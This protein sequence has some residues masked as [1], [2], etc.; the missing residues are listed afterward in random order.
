MTQVHYIAHHAPRTGY[1]VGSFSLRGPRGPA[2]LRGPF[3]EIASAISRCP[4]STTYTFDAIA[5]N[6][7]SARRQGLTTSSLDQV[8]DIPWVEREGPPLDHAVHPDT[9]ARLAQLM[10]LIEAIGT[11]AEKLSARPPYQVA[12]SPNTMRF[13]VAFS[14]DYHRVDAYADVDARAPFVRWVI[15]ARRIDGQSGSTLHISWPWLSRTMQIDFGAIEIRRIV[16]PTAI[17]LTALEQQ[18]IENADAVEGGIWHGIPHVWGGD[19][20]GQPIVRGRAGGCPWDLRD[21]MGRDNPNAPGVDPTFG[22]TWTALLWPVEGLPDPRRLGDLIVWGVDC[23]FARRPQH[24]DVLAVMEPDGKHTLH[25]GQPY[26]AEDAAFFGVGPQFRTGP[27][28]FTTHDHEHRSVAPLAV[29]AALTGDVAAR[30]VAES[31]LAAESW[32]RSVVMGW[33]QPGRGNGLPWIAGSLLARVTGDT[34]LVVAWNHHS[35]ERLRQLRDKRLQGYP[36]TVAGTYFR[37]SPWLVDG[38]EQ[39]YSDPYE[40]ATIVVACWLEFRRTGDREF[41][42]I[43]LELGRGVVAGH[44]RDSDGTARAAYNMRWLGGNWPHTPGGP[45]NGDLRPGGDALSRWAG[46]GLHC[47]LLAGDALGIADA[48][49]PWRVFARGLI[50]DLARGAEALPDGEW[51]AAWHRGWLGVAPPAPIA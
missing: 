16:V 17:D 31:F 5:D 40:Q 33:M 29:C 1:F 12:S 43:A 38:A 47:Y 48:A 26:D 42:E 28:V 46:C 34:S 35:S 11:K 10:P 9:I 15:L 13:K 41:A 2:V 27:D 50:P 44:Y 45:I 22:S 39:P 30:E 37:G 14:G 7:T 36:I 24:W 32:E 20:L 49:E 19:L 25:K 18:A 21:Y 23:G 4:E 8:C 3:N 51:L 6:W